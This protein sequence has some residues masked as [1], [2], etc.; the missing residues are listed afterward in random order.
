MKTIREFVPA[1]RYV[2]DCGP[3]SCAKGFAQVD[4]PQD[5]SYFGTWASPSRRMVVSYCEGDVTTEICE[6]DAEFVALLR[7]IDQWNIEHQDGHAKIDPGLGPELK[8]AFEQIGLA[9]MLH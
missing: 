7:E 2:Y 4:T 5:A 1:D 3:C 6:N 8:A 9:D